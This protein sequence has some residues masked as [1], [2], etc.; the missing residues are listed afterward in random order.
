DKENHDPSNK[1]VLFDV[2]KGEDAW[3]EDF[4]SAAALVGSD[5]DAEEPENW[6][7]QLKEH[8]SLT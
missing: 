3:I 1:E 8:L 5:G 6:E 4:N 2:T 7:E